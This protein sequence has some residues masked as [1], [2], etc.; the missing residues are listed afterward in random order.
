MSTGRAPDLPS[1]FHT[2]ASLLEGNVKPGALVNVIGIVTDHRLPTATS[3]SDWKSALTLRDLDVEGAQEGIVLNIFR[4]EAQMPEV[5]ARDVFVA[6][7]VKFQEY[8]GGRSLISHRTTNFARY[9]ASKIPKLPNSAKTALIPVSKR[10]TKT[11]IEDIHRFVSYHFHRT[12]KYDLPDD[13][14]FRQKASAS[15]NIKGKKFSELKDVK[16][17]AFY[18]LVGFVP[19]DPYSSGDRATLYLT[20]YTENNKFFDFSAEGPTV[21]SA[22][23]YGYTR[24]SSSP[25]TT[26]DQKSSWLGPAG[27]LSIQITCFEPHAGFVEAE[28]K[29]GM[30]V[31]LNNVRICYG[32]NISNLEGKMD[33]ER[34]FNGQSRVNVHIFDTSPDRFADLDPNLKEVLKRM[35]QYRKSHKK[36]KAEVDEAVEKATVA[37][38]KRRAALE[39]PKPPE[40]SKGQQAKA[41]T[42]PTMTK[43]RLRRQKKRERERAK[44][45]GQA[46]PAQPEQ[47]TP[48]KQL[49]QPRPDHDGSG[50]SEDDETNESEESLPEV[51]PA[52]ACERPRGQ[53]LTRI[54]K[55][56]ETKYH[57]LPMGKQTIRLALPFAN[58]KYVTRARVVD[59]SPKSLEGFAH[60]RKTSLMDLVRAEDGTDHEAA[61]ASS[62]DD[63]D[64]YNTLLP[65]ES[66]VWEWNFMLELEDADRPS[67]S[68]EPA[69]V[70]VLVDNPA[71]QCL[72]GLDAGDLSNDEALLD[73]LRER[74]FT[75]W[76]NLEE[77]KQ[78]KRK[79]SRGSKVLVD[80]PP[81]SS[82]EEEEELANRPFLCCVKQYGVPKTKAKDNIDFKRAFALFGTMIKG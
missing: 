22:D 29:A 51:N 28:V 30:F 27:K 4:P 13:E 8:K 43:A 50:N 1:G 79:A 57:E 37:G 59:F 78:I 66:V 73:K 49:A 61:G 54:E 44:A 26:Q 25:T 55:M 74:M 46:Q 11:P 63:D 10:D 75:M 72:T 38:S 9:S 69:R 16:D 32:H 82:D 45:E 19:R 53:E 70:W 33:G 56:L 23:P 34:N 14:E 65:H 39:P 18:D 68:R 52:I 81:A 31:G 5:D 7:A 67:R 76:G 48:A 40:P 58:A 2:V 3:A 24:A 17:G 62:S 12:E 47:S 21:T 80:K 20:D 15:M 64:D 71:G 36:R 6:F 35:E 41:T 77:I 42:K 60:R